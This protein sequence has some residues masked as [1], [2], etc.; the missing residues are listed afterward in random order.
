MSRAVAELARLAVDTGQPLAGLLHRHAME[1]LVHRVAEA[2][3]GDEL[4]LRGSLLTRLWARPAYRPALDIDYVTTYAFDPDRAEAAIRLACSA[5]A[6]DDGVEFLPDAIAGEVTWADTPF[7]G[8]R[9][10]VPAIVGEVRL[11]LQIDVGYGDPLVP[12]PV[13]VELPTLWPRPAARVLAC[14]PEL[15]CAWKVHGLFEFAHW[16][17]KDL[18]DVYLIARNTPL[19]RAMLTEALRVAF[20]SRGTPLADAL[21]LFRGEF[22][23]SRGSRAKWRAFRR[24]RAD[25]S[26]PADHR[27]VV[28]FVAEILHPVFGRLL[29]TSSRGPIGDIAGVLRGAGGQAPGAPP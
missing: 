14:R 16:R 17:A 29:D 2:A 25:P 8:T 12:P 26:I 18:H 3:E 23:A 10:R 24:E 9:L 7:P 6:S 5:G 27:E 19:D 22:G 13:R 28:R 21:R 1:A 15:G 11:V 20:E 4:V